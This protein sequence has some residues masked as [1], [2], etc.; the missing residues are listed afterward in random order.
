M[1][2]FRRYYWD[3]RGGEFCAR[4]SAD[5]IQVVTY[6]AMTAGIVLL[7]D[8]WLR[9]FALLSAAIV[10]NGL[11]CNRWTFSRTT[12]AL[13]QSRTIANVPFYTMTI[14]LAAL[15]GIS[16]VDAF[17]HRRDG[18]TT[19]ISVL[20]LW[21]TGEAPI[22]IEMTDRESSEA[23]G[24]DLRNFYGLAQVSLAKHRAG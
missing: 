2:P 6:G 24:E 11:I 5:W 1:E 21:R 22:E 13:H 17:H 23:L 3:T 18:G 19:R 12:P 7:L 9:L 16:V 10:C 8:G 4:E 14:D 15:S 20:K